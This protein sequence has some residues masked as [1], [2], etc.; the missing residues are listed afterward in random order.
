MGMRVGSG[1]A[2][3]GVRLALAYGTCGAGLESGSVEAGS[4]G[5][6]FEVADTVEFGALGIC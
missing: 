4:G 5:V 2:A 1:L 3:L 6:V